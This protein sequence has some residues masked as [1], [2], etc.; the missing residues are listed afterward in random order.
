MEERSCTI[1]LLD[2]WKFHFRLMLMIHYNRC[3][4]L[5]IFESFN[6]FLNHDETD[7]SSS[8]DND[9][10][11]KSFNKPISAMSSSVKEELLLS[12]VVAD[13]ETLELVSSI[14]Q[15]VNNI[16]INIPI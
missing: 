6:T 16:I 13:A 15:I 3:L 1:C 2:L 4:I 11:L 12:V 10:A 9:S 5:R 8:L 7:L 14:N